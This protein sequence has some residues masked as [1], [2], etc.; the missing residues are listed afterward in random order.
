MKIDVDANV[1][2]LLGDSCECGDSQLVIPDTFVECLTYEMQI[3]WLKRYI[4]SVAEG[5]DSEAVKQLQED[6]KQLQENYNN[7][8]IAQIEQSI[9]E[10][11]EAVDNIQIST[12]EIGAN[13][14]WYINGEDTGKPSR[15]EQGPAGPKG[16]A[17]EAGPEGPAGPQGEQGPQGPQGEAGPAGPKG[18]TGEQG[19]AGEQ[20][21][22]GDTGE[23]G[24]AGEQGP[25]GDQGEQ[26]PVGPEGPEGPMGPQGPEGPAGPKGD[27]GEQGPAGATGVTPDITVSATVDETTGTPDVLVTKSGTL[28]N[29][30]FDFEFTGLKGEAGGSVGVTTQTIYIKPQ[31]CVLTNKLKIATKDT[32]GS[33]DSAY[34][35]TMVIEE[36]QFTGI[37]GKVGCVDIVVLMKD[38]PYNYGKFVFR[39]WCTIPQDKTTQTL[40]LYP[41]FISQL[42]KKN[43]NKPMVWYVAAGSVFNNNTLEI[44]IF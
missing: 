10:L 39:C 31:E 12:P 1:K 23:Q 24:P 41:F 37:A 8:P 22:K 13:G 21:P 36:T 3:M 40:T 27:P 32:G 30:V 25:K 7:L 2:F 19:P 43:I 44:Q 28:E 29:P 16:D 4:D 5:G 20:G 17:G 15:G 38:D 34:A 9:K 6:V 11:K 33:I 18:D 26:G 35:S 14:N 42:S